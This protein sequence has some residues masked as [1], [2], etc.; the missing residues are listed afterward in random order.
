MINGENGRCPHCDSPRL[1]KAGKHYTSSG[2][3]Q[4]YLCRDCHRHTVFPK[5]QLEL[6][7]APSGG[8]RTTE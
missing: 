8:A 3:K 2:P 7:E 4:R 6:M 1:N 5:L